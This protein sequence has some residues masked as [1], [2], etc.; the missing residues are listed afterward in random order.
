MNFLHGMMN[1][2]AHRKD[3]LLVVFLGLVVFMIII[4]LPTWLI[5]AAI[6]LNFAM[7]LLI[8]MVGLYLTSS[9]EF[10]TL[11]AVILMTTLFRLAISISTTR[12]ILLNADAGKIVETF[13]QFVVGGSLVVGIIIFLIIT[14][15][16]F[17]VITRG[18]ERV[19]EVA[20]RFSLDAMP[21]RQMAIDSDIRTGEL[22]MNTAKVS[23]QKL[24]VESQFYGAMDG[25]MKFIK[26]DSI[27]GIIIILVNLIGGVLVGVG[28]N[29]MEM[30]EAGQLYTILTVGDGLVSQIPALIISISA[31]SIVTRVS[32]IDSTDL[33]NEIAGQLSANPNS[34]RLTGLLLISFALIPGF[35]RIPFLVAA[36]LTFAAGFFVARKLKETAHTASLEASHIARERLHE[37]PIQ[38]YVSDALMDDFDPEAFHAASLEERRM[39]LSS[40]GVLFPEFA[41]NPADLPRRTVEI[42]IEGIKILR[43]EIPAN[44]VLALD[45]PENVLSI[46]GA[47]ALDGPSLWHGSRSSTWVGSDAEALLVENEIPVLSCE[48]SIARSVSYALPRHIN[49]FLGVQE[50]RQILNKANRKYPDLVEE[51]L[52]AVSLPVISEIFQ[53]LVREEISIKDIRSILEGIIK[54]APKEKDTEMLSEYVRSF[55]AQQISSKISPDTK[56]I[57]GFVFSPELEDVIRDSTRVTAVGSYLSLPPEQ[58]KKIIDEINSKLGDADSHESSPTFIAS[59]DVRRVLRKFLWT[60][61]VFCPIMS[62]QDVAPDFRVQLLGEIGVP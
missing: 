26:G 2:L 4:P 10:T 12:Q 30:A 35:P 25:T 27:A 15:V 19:A 5:D 52:E 47:E 39:L 34:L 18:A 31:G 44:A 53:D 20:A 62:Q 8:L 50:T 45:T 37:S 7:A 6:T 28:Q 55:I 33:G 59:M 23:R 51:A 58:R 40:L 22:D 48:Q 57:Y 1:T 43:W 21:G 9:S 3:I 61:N 56:T 49:Y 54:W 24:Q 13:G 14:I 17:I 38:V 29:G 36:G 46:R 32:N 41:L 60:N 11:P 16:Q 42:A